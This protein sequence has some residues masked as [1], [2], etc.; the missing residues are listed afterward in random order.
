MGGPAAG[1]MP[2]P[3]QPLTA[4]TFWDNYRTACQAEDRAAANATRAQRDEVTLAR[5]AVLMQVLAPEPAALRKGLAEYLG[6]LAHPEA[7]RA[8]ARLAI[9]SAEGEVRQV[10]LDALKVRRE[11]D[12]TDVLLQG[13]SYPYA[14][15]ARRAAEA[16]V[17]LQR[18]DLVPQLI[19][20]LEA[21][22]PRGPAE[23]EVNGKRVPVVREL[24]RVNHHRNCLMCHAPGNTPDVPPSTVTGAIPT[25]GEPLPSP[26]D[27]YRGSSPDV[28][29]RIDV[30][31]LRQDFSVMQSVADAHPWPEK[32]RFDFLVRTRTLTDS[33]AEAFREKLTP[34]EPGRFSPYHRAILAA[35]RE[36]TG[37]D[38]APSADGWR[39]L[40]GLPGARQATVLH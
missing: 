2:M 21:A 23:Q 27:G 25:P 11:R 28:F 18:K 31:Y 16:L 20:L 6:T 35:L 8:L 39:R 12:Y 29:V 26:F 36:L 40:L 14:P 33:E 1:T 37:R 24:V 30:T 13:L 4:D 3:G 5:I 17:K 19:D 10:A 15:V 7:T 34:R 9:F 38:T 32:Q 22:D